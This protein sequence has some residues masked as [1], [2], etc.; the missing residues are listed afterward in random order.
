MAISDKIRALLSSAGKKQVD[1]LG[2]LGVSSKQA[3]SNK[4]TNGRWSADEL[5]G[6]ADFIGCELAFILPDGTKIVLN[7]SKGPDA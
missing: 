6:I 4:F 7:K 1:L 5:A 3:L 2:I